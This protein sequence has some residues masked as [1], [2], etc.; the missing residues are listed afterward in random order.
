MVG[1]VFSVAE[2]DD[3]MSDPTAT[4]VTESIVSPPADDALSTL[5]WFAPPS[6]VASANVI[7]WLNA[8][9]LPAAQYCSDVSQKILASTDDACSTI[10]PPSTSDA[11]PAFTSMNVSVY[12]ETSTLDLSYDP[13]I[14]KLPVIVT[15]PVMSTPPSAPVNC[16]GVF[17]TPPSLT[18]NFKSLSCEVCATVTLLLVTVTVNSC[19]SP[20]II[21]LSVSMVR[22]PVVVSA[23]F[24]L[25]KLAPPCNVS[26]GDD[27]LVVSDVSK[28]AACVLEPSNT[29]PSVEFSVIPALIVANPVCVT[30][31]VKVASDKIATR[32]LP[33]YMEDTTLLPPEL[34]SVSIFQP[35]SCCPEV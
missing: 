32:V 3:V 27:A 34:P 7:T 2:V 4:N 15:S 17:V 30:L 9:V 12:V 5:L 22:A 25:R 26:P 8:P 16:R 24:D 19:A 20:T 13:D 33:A 14:V 10:S 11:W 1:T 35:E 18:V 28:V 29:A 23:A 6:S 21:P 31:G